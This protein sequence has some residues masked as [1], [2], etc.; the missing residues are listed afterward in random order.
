MV[1]ITVVLVLYGTSTIIKQ[2]YIIIHY[3]QGSQG[4]IFQLDGMCPIFWCH[5]KKLA[6]GDTVVTTAMGYFCF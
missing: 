5:T 3:H 2:V 4:K 1:I 6:R